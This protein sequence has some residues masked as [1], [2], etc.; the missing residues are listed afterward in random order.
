MKN[1]AN[2]RYVC[3]RAIALVTI[4]AA[5]T[6]CNTAPVRDPA[7][8]PTWPSPPVGHSVSGNGAIYQSGQSTALFEDVRARRIGDILV[9]RLQESTNATKSSTTS[10]DKSQSS[11][12]TNPTIFGSTPS[13]DLPGIAP[14]ASTSDN[15][16]ET[17]ISSANEFEGGGDSA[18][19]NSL[20]GD[21]AVTVA[22]VLPNGNLYVRGEKRLSLNQGNEYV[23]IAGIVRPIDIQSDNSVLS[24]QIADATIAYSGDGALADSNR[25]G[26]LA[27]FFNSAIFPL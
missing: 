25:P 12:L 9:V 4:T 21:I 24:T 8:A 16:L 1:T 20:S 14:L 23:R 13:F 3:Q 26:W 17:S 6:A 10:T 19:S 2:I 7:F 5:L 18:Q 15:T 27:R 11:T 22:D